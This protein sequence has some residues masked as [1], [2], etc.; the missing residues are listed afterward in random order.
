MGAL[1]KNISSIPDAKELL[2]DFLSQGNQVIIGKEEQMKL[3]ICCLLAKG[4]LLIEDIP[5]VGKTTMVKYLAA[6]MGLDVKRIQF[7]N[8]LLPSDITGTTIYNRDKNTFDFHKGPLFAEVVIADELNRAT[9]KTQSA[10][11]QAMEERQISV[12]GIA[13]SLPNP[14]FVIATQNPQSQMGTY[15]LPESQ[16]DRF[17]MSLQLGYPSVEAERKLLKGESRIDLLIDI[18]PVISVVNLT[19]L[20]SRIRETIHVADP[21]IDYIQRLLLASR[22]RDD[23][24]GLSPRAG[25][26]LVAS[27]RSWAYLQ[28][29]DWVAPEDVQAV[30]AP[31]AGHRLTSNETFGI[32]YG[33]QL[34]REI[35]GSVRVD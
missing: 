17:L 33:W 2:N 10:C 28:G 9:P 18:K 35:L 30:F 11:L 32:R 8:D 15:P 7:T 23:C 24:F 16:L 5:G 6:A 29:R 34:S 19:Q 26:A 14:F 25:L 31:V 27:S 20:Q 3:A 22:G 1:L 12:D 21:I 4:H 13:Y